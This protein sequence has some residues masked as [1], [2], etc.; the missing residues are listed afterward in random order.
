VAS[1]VISGSYSWWQQCA[2]AFALVGALSAGTADAQ[3]GNAAGAMWGTNPS[4]VAV[5]G[6]L[7]SAATHNA[8]GSIAAAV[9]AAKKGALI[10]NGSS[11]SIS[12]V[13]SQTIV[14]S[15]I[16]GNDNGGVDIN[17]TQSSTNSGSQTTDGTFN[18]TRVNSDSKRG[19]IVNNNTA[20]STVTNE[21]GQ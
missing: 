18:V 14:S 11:Y 8:N 21:S 10:G 9:N 6:A 4:G 16:I 20:G 15:T 12:T 2:V 17:A 19:G 7:E 13:G 1:T 3:V 5:N